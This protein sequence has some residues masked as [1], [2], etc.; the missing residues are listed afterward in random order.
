MSKIK[1]R[2]YSIIILTEQ[3]HGQFGNVFRMWEVC[4]LLD[5]ITGQI[6]ALCRTFLREI[7]IAIKQEQKS[8]SVSIF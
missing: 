4:G 2:K 5:D 3:C 8:T 7:M 6:L 1:D